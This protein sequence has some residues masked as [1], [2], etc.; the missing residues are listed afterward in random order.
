MLFLIGFFFRCV[1]SLSVDRKFGS[2]L[3]N[4]SFTGMLGMLQ[5]QEVD[6][7]VSSLIISQDRSLAAD[8]LSPLAPAL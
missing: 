5:R 3:D 7:A 1:T 2:K 4:G 8:F 6:F